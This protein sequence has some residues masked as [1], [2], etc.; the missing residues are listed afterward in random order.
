MNATTRNKFM[1]LTFD[2]TPQ[3]VE[4]IS[5]IAA[6]LNDQPVDQDAA[7]RAMDELK[8][9]L[10]NSKIP[11]KSPAVVGTPVINVF[12]VRVANSLLR[13]KINFVEEIDITNLHS[14]KG[15]GDKSIQL[16]VNF[17]ERGIT[18]EVKKQDPT[19]SQGEWV[20][21]FDRY[22]KEEVA[23]FDRQ[24]FDFCVHE[25][26]CS[27]PQMK[28]HCLSPELFDFLVLATQTRKQPE[29]MQAF[30]KACFLEKKSIAKSAELIGVTV[31]HARRKLEKFERQAHF[32]ARNLI[33]K[34]EQDDQLFC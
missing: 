16:I 22:T 20:S 2:C 4:A 12:P 7:K 33:K 15:L 11:V 27:Y 21:L 26:E 32:Y 29:R 14:V 18:P 3:N 10:D 13:S 23:Q 9:K 30:V 19:K 17:V 24:L 34:F 1:Q 5:T 25:E 28:L 31:T 8:R 6:I